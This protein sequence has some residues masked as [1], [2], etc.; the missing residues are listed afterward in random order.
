[1]KHNRILTFCLIL[2]LALALTLGTAT[3]ETS[4]QALLDQVYQTVIDRS[5]TQ[6][7][8]IDFGQEVKPEN[9]V[10]Y[11]VEDY[12]VW[13]ADTDGMMSLV[14]YINV[15]LSS[16]Y[17][18]EGSLT[19]CDF[20]FI[21][22]TRSASASDTLQHCYPSAVYD[23]SRTNAQELQWPIAVYADEKTELALEFEVPADTVRFGL[24]CTNIL[25]TDGADPQPM[26][27]IYTLSCTRN[28]ADFNLH[29]N[30][31]VD[32]AEL[33]VSPEG[34]NWSANLI[35][36]N[37]LTT[38]PTQKWCYVSLDDD[39]NQDVQATSWAIKVVMSDGNT[40]NFSD[41]DLCNAYDLY[42]SEG[43]NGGDY[44]LSIDE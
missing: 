36:S 11:T 17:E 33:Y 34:G 8:E 5:T 44:T 16:A 7:V 14:F 28:L 29:N 12:N 32:I 9:Y 30:T 2:C 35:E 13:A 21:L 40:I 15:G 10:T 19:M 42:V 25:T 1:M 43:E 3:A 31:T 39:E 27:D 26:G 24:I 20:D 41:A 22:L 38:L 18:N 23:L 4:D 37:G 6:N